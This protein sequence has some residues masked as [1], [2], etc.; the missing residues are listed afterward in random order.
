LSF[1]ILC[2]LCVSVVKLIRERWRDRKPGF[3]ELT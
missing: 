2:E 1:E 3:A